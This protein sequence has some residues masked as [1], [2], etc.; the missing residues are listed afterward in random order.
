M[1]HGAILKVLEGRATELEVNTFSQW[2]AASELHRHEFKQVMQLWQL[3]QKPWPEPENAQAL[4]RLRECMKTRQHRKTLTKR[5]RAAACLVLIFIIAYWLWP[6][7][8]SHKHI[9]EEL[10]FNH[11][12][13]TEVAAHLETKFDIKIKIIGKELE[14]YLFTGSFSK[15]STLSDVMHGISLSLRVNV[16][17]RRSGYEWDYNRY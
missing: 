11:A 4:M 7:A 17:S 13:L 2:M 16:V 5:L 9:D 8:N 10:T 15:S 12:P 6:T 3:T 1:D 14:T